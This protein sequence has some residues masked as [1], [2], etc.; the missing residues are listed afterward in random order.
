GYHINDYY[1]ALEHFS[2]FVQPGFQRI[3]S[4]TGL[5]DLL[6][7]AY[8][9]EKRLRRLVVVLINTSASETLTPALALPAA[10]SGATEVYRS[11]FSGTT[12]RF[13]SLG[14]LAA[15]N[16]VTLPP[17]SVATI[18]VEGSEE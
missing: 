13:S 9:V 1:Y 12:E 11:T 6:A 17:Q 14:P 3:A 10:W 18:V 15:N 8:Y 5:A 2:R 4:P 16:V 7:S